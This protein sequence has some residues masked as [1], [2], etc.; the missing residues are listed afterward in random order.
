MQ[1]TLANAPRAAE[2]VVVVEEEIAGTIDEVGKTIVSA[3]TR[4]ISI[5]RSSRDTTMV[6]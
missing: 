3:S 1:H 4:S 2:D 5:T 6:Y